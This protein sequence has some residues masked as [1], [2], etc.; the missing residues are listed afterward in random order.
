VVLSALVALW[1]MGTYTSLV[2]DD[3]GTL[4][5]DVLSSNEVVLQAVPVAALP[6]ESVVQEP[7][8]DEDPLPPTP[9][10]GSE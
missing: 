3:A 8:E 1:K 6:L 10:E 7:G 4:P 9:D 5:E 2:L